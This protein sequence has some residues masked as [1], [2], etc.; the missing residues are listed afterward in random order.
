MDLLSSFLMIMTA[1]LRLPT[2]M[3][4]GNESVLIMRLK[5]SLASTTPSLCI[6]I[7]NDILVTPAGN[8]TSYNPD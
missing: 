1:L 5:F 3:P 4:L 2:I 7:L 8:V 6:G